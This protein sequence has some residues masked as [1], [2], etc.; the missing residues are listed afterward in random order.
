[1]RLMVVISCVRT[2]PLRHLDLEELSSAEF[3]LTM[4]A[5]S[6]RVSCLKAPSIHTAH[7]YL[8]CGGFIG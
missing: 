6:E 8:L 4:S 5:D 1:M 7:D 3:I 2:R